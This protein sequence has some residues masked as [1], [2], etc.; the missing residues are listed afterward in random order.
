MQSAFIF[1]GTAGHPKENWFPWLKEKL[2][3]ESCDVFVPQFPTPQ[4]QTLDAWMDVFEKYDAGYLP[5]SIA[6]GHSLGGAF[7]LRVLEKYDV[8]IGLAAFVAAPVGVLPI[9]NFNS[10]RVFLSAP[11]DW[12]KIRARSEKFLVFQSDNDPLVCLGNGEMLAE[13]LGVGLELVKGAG[14]FNQVAGYT[15]FE[16]L[17]KRMEQYLQTVH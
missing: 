3:G 4:G 14:H 9:R 17:W 7:L 2:E 8:K 16:L 6:V 5:G 15:K 11:F 13:K 1:H 10:D 12:E